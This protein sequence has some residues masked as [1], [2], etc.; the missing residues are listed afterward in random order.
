MEGVFESVSEVS[1]KVCVNEWIECWIEVTD[2]EEYRN[3]NIGAGTQFGSTER[4]YHIPQEERQP[5]QKENSWTKGKKKKTL[6]N[7]FDLTLI[8]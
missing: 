5:A 4:C 1:V 6:I 3:Q 2:P 8:N 7:Y